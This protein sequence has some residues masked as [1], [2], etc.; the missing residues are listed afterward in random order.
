MLNP[1]IIYMNAGVALLTIYCT[2]I[3]ISVAV[4]QIE[5]TTTPDYLILKFHLE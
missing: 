3:K 5:L 4:I 2:I 1:V